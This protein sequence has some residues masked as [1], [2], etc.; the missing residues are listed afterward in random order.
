MILYLFKYI[1]L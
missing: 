1:E